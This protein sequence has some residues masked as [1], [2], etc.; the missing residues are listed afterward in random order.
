MSDH[1]KIDE[2]TAL[3]REQIA[4]KPIKSCGHLGMHTYLPSP[5]RVGRVESDVVRYVYFEDASEC[6]VLG[7]LSDYVAF[8]AA[9]YGAVAAERDAARAE[10][11]AMRADRDAALLILPASCGS[12]ADAADTLRQ[13]HD[14][15]LA[16]VMDA[17]DEFREWADSVADQIEGQ[18]NEVCR[19]H[20]RMLAALRTL[21]RKAKHVENGTRAVVESGSLPAHLERAEQPKPA[22]PSFEPR[23]WWVVFGLERSAASRMHGEARSIGPALVERSLQHLVD[24][25]DKRGVHPGEI[26]RALDEARA[27]LLDEQPKPAGGAS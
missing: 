4:A 13:E 25:A 10:L 26:R 15:L 27:E 11:A 9:D 2:A 19:D 7:Q 6:I 22:A 18:E 12:L 21:R 20:N 16:A 17:T 14:A 3:W 23:P 1:Q 5:A 8:R 24:D